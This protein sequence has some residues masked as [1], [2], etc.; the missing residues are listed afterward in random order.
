MLKIVRAETA[1]LE[2]KNKEINEELGKKIEPE[3]IPYKH[4]LIKR[5]LNQRK[6][7]EAA[8]I[9]RI[10]TD[11]IVR[12][13]AFKKKYDKNGNLYTAYTRDKKH[14]NKPRKPNIKYRELEKRIPALEKR[15]SESNNPTKTLRDV[16]THVW[17]YLKEDTH[18]TEEYPGIIF[19]GWNLENVPELRKLKKQKAE[20]KKNEKI[21]TWI[22]G[23]KTM[24][25]FKIEL[26]LDPQEKQLS[27][28]E[29]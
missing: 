19:P 10:L 27:K 21:E 9:V 17:T 15:V 29:E 18:V 16:F 1:R 12:S 3:Q 25:K 8:D 5:S 14:G 6:D 11:T 20:L 26:E 24:D 23:L 2:N 13:G 4:T 7:R 22:P 28:Y